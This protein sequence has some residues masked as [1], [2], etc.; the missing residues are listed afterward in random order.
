MATLDQLKVQIDAG[1]TARIF[2]ASS[3]FGPRYLDTETKVFKDAQDYVYQLSYPQQLDQPKPSCY[4][5]WSA[6]LNRL[7]GTLLSR[8]DWEIE[9]KSHK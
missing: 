1:F 6:L 5:D 4:P 8:D 2:L 9:S 7:G 3:Q